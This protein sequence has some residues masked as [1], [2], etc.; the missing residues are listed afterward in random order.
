MFCGRCGAQVAGDAPYCLGCGAPRPEAAR[1]APQADTYPLLAAANLARVRRQ[2]QD[3]ASKCLEVLRRQPRH[4]TAHSLLGDIY[5]DQGKLRD[6]IEWYRLALELD[7]TSAADR[8]KLDQLVDQVYAGAGRPRGARKEPPLARFANRVCALLRC[9]DLPRP[10]RL[11]MAATG[12]LVL[13]LVVFVFA[14]R[15]SMAPAVSARAIQI[16]KPGEAAPAPPRRPFA[17]GT[18]TPA[19]AAPT[20][21]ATRPSGETPK[22][23]AAAEGANRTQR[24]GA[25]GAPPSFE[26]L[27]APPPAGENGPG[28]VAR[29]ESLLGALRATT[30]KGERPRA[31]DSVWIDPRTQVAYVDFRA[32]ELATPTGTKRNLILVALALAGAAHRADPALATITLRGALPIPDRGGKKAPEYAFVGE[33]NVA[34]LP[35]PSAAPLAPDQAL[36]LFGNVWWHPLFADL[37]P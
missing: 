10:L 16:H 2:Y 23:S 25:T 26:P 30:I 29:Q 7:P 35:D 20:A 21:G 27:L 33:I 11:A 36:A 18:P 31:I 32:P 3:A 22:G 1:A 19:P 17:G 34:R 24:Q 28:L 4:P 9:A 6:A 5:R 12:V 8:K 37:V 14:Y 15:A 13:L